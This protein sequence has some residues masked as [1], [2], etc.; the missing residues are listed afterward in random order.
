MAGLPDLNSTL[1]VELGGDSDIGSAG[2]G[3]SVPY[4]LMQVGT[5][6]LFMIERPDVKAGS[7]GPLLRDVDFEHDVFRSCI[8]SRPLVE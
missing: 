2:Y 7:T 3:S 4:V 6:C 1:L 8:D 5:C